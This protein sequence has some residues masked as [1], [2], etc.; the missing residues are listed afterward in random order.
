[1][2]TILPG[3]RGTAI[4]LTTAK[5]YTPSHRV[6]HEKGIAPNII[7]TL[8]VPEE[9]ALMDWRR[10]HPQASSDPTQIAQLGDK[11]LERA[12]AA[13]KALLVK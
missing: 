7:S 3:E 4:R 6:I 10:N 2:Q 13:M 1:V 5:Y 11:Q 12:V 8:S 9:K